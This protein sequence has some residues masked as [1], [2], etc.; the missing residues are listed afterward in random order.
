MD[1]AAPAPLLPA[2]RPDLRLFDGGRDATGEPTFLI[3]DAVRHRY[4]HIGW[5]AFAMLARWGRTTRRELQDSIKADLDVEID[6][7]EIEGLI[8]FLDTQELTVDGV[9]TG[10]RRNLVLA[11]MRRSGPAKWLLHNY[12]YFRIPLLR[13]DQW[14]SRLLPYV[15]FVFSRTFWL[16]WLVLTL[17]A[18]YLATREW[19]DFAGAWHRVFDIQGLLAF[20]G[21][22]I[23]LKS[24]HE[25]GHA[26]VAK[27]LGCRIAS[28][29][30]VFMVLAPILYT[31]TTDCWRLPSRL[32]RWRIASAGVLA[33]IMIAPVALL[34]WSFMTTGFVRDLFFAAAVL[35]PSLSLLVNLNPLM[36]FD[37]YFMLSDLL[38]FYNL[39]PRSFA[40]GRWKLRETLFAHGAPPPENLPQPLTRLLIAYAYATWIYRLLLFIGIAI[41]VYA[42]IVKVVG[43][44]LFIVE[45]GFFV[46]RPVAAELAVWW[47]MRD[48]ARLRPRTVMIWGG[49]LVVLLALVLPWRTTITIPAV[50]EAGRL[51]VIHVSAPAQI[52]EVF[53]KDGETVV[54]GQPLLRLQAPDLESLA[55]ISRRRMT[56]LE[57]RLA[58]IAGSSVDL[59]DR[60]VAEQELR[61]ER[62]SLAGIERLRQELVVKAPADGLIRDLD[63]KLRAGMWLGTRDQIAMLVDA[64]TYR[65]RGFVSLTDVR[66]LKVG[67]TGS[68][69]ADDGVLELAKVRL[70]SINRAADRRLSIPILAEPHGGRI[71][72]V[73]DDKKAIYSHE[74]MFSVRLALDSG[75][76]VGHLLRGVAV[77]DGEPESI[78]FRL[79]RR[80][81]QVLMRESGF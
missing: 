6:D 1:V 60:L 28:M 13:P 73:V 67:M 40:F 2:L 30:I 16:C 52:V 45:I 76:T 80:I 70:A 49:L 79:L 15:A 51:E 69:I 54:A 56:L 32:Q 18:I 19:A 10:W 29:G 24:V 14:L 46:V 37:G 75:E 47:R 4:F 22:L 8:R 59:E 23:V 7:Q 68:F 11:D 55:V 61:S 33:E 62:Q 27:R 26:L 35:A 65:L 39:Q 71:E 63:R 72:A 77:I 38:G 25:L 57:L 43:I 41:F 34:I 17:S 74:A 44:I 50:V 48:Q 42:F 12:L 58:R 36:R 64:K 20:A 9:N 66:R 5:H 3:F 31:D 78:L 53:V 81:G 21:G